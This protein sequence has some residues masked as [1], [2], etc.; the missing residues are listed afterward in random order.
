[1]IA[2]STQLAD[3]VHEIFRAAGSEPEEAACVS[4]HLVQANLEGHDSHGVI[5]IPYYMQWLR[6]ENFRPNQKLQLVEVAY[7]L[8]VDESL[9]QSALKK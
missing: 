8:G 6:E 4:N 2:F 3:L 1:M 7:R 9:I 5:R